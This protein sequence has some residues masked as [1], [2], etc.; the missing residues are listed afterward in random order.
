MNQGYIYGVYIY[1]YNV[2]ILHLLPA[3]VGPQNLVTLR[4]HETIMRNKPL[5]RWCLQEERSKYSRRQGGV[6]KTSKPR[7]NKKPARPRH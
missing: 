7:L 3:G 4:A 5:G 1:I 2:N 6:R